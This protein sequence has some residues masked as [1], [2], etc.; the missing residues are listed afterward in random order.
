[1]SNSVVTFFYNRGMPLYQEKRFLPGLT[2][3]LLA[4][5]FFH[6]VFL[7]VVVLLLHTWDTKYPPKSMF[8]TLVVLHKDYKVSLQYGFKDLI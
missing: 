6:L 4:S 2:V 5:P 8:F 3:G 1:M 7:L